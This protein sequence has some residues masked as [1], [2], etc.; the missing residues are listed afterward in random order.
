MISHLGPQLALADGA[1][2]AYKLRKQIKYRLHSQVMAV[3][4]KAIFM[5]HLTLLRCGIFL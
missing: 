2:L 1:A 3:P 5:K 4:A